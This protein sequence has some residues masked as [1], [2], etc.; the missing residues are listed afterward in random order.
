M[1][2][3]RLVLCI[4]VAALC[5][6]GGGAKKPDPEDG[7]GP[8]PV[9]PDRPRPDDGLGSTSELPS[10]P[11]SAHPPYG[12]TWHVGFTENVSLREM[13]DF[14]ATLVSTNDTLWSISEGQVRVHRIRIRD[15]VAPGVTASAYA[16]GG[17]PL[18]TSDLDIV[19]WP[20]RMWDV[21][22]LGAVGEIGGRGGRI[23]VMPS[24][25][26]TF[27]VVHEASHFLFN[28]TWSVGPL[29]V[30]EY[31]D[32]VQDAACIME[33]ELFPVRW[34]AQANHTHQCSQPHACWTQILRDYA[35]FKHLG[36]DIAASMA[37]V[38]LVEFSDS[39]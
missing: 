33:S 1:R 32:G 15:N 10:V 6:C 23:A 35:N 19:I 37:P 2:L 29:L 26:T 28:L 27:V 7:S 12:V 36:T 38:P 14:Y 17:A 11:R 22:F 3:D 9:P 24:D 5:A 18:D 21:P 16:F 13:Q 31:V 30:D 39:P 8:F 4:A 34:C 20:P 25:A